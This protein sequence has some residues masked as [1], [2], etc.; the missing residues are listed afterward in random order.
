MEPT[1]S[2]FPTSHVTIR[3]QSERNVHN[4][5]T[6]DQ[7]D[8]VS[9]RVKYNALGKTDWWHFED[10]HRNDTN[11][12]SNNRYARKQGKIPVVKIDSNK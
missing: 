11:V 3:A 10:R 9:G 8:D 5:G 2:Q 1:S 4:E 7:F 6:E 12:K